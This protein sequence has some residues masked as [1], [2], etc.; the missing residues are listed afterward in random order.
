[1]DNRSSTRAS[2]A[3]RSR[4]G[5]WL[6]FAAVL[7]LLSTG[8]CQVCV[9]NVSM[10]AAMNDEG[11]R[12][13]A[14]HVASVVALAAFVAGM[15]FLG[16]GIRALRRRDRSQHDGAPPTKTTRPEPDQRN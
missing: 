6:T 1:M 2:T 7:L 3:G 11:E 9:M 4:P 15:T 13:F 16:V 8:A 14:L 5:L 12:A 10:G